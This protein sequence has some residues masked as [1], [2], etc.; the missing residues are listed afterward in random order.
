MLELGLFY[1]PTALPAPRPQTHIPPP[2]PPHTCMVEFTNDRSVCVYC[3]L[4]VVLWLLASLQAFQAFF[5]F[6]FFFF[7]FVC[8]VFVFIVLFIV[9]CYCVGW[10]LS[11]IVIYGRGRGLIVL[12]FVGLCLWHLFCH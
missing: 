4:G 8:F 12:L 5:F 7:F 10:N 2:P 3:V 9:Y 6:F 1:Y 11:G